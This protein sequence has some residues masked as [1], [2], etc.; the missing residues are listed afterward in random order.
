MDEKQ[1]LIIN[2]SRKLFE[3]RGFNSTSIDD[4]VKSCKISKATFY[5]YFSTKE[6]LV[7]EIMLYFNK[8]FLDVNLLID[9]K[10][11]LTGREKLKEK[12]VMVWKYIYSQSICNNYVMEVVASNKGEDIQVLRKKARYDLVREYYNSLIEVYKEDAKSVIW[13]LIFC[14]DAFIHE[15][16][17]IIRMRKEEIE[18]EFIA[19]FIIEMIEVIINTKK[20]REPMIREGFFYFENIEAIEFI[21]KEKLFERR[22]L[23]IKEIIELNDINLKDKLLEAIEVINIEFNEKRYD[24]LTIEAMIAFLEKE[25]S[26]YKEVRALDYIRNQ[27]I[28]ERD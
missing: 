10:D 16:I 11:D 23:I 5:K 26:I 15:F 13:D 22:L 12:I 19:E 9:S 7:Y 14:L 1:K 4:I 21:E 25:E 17:F 28:K 2:M 18:P 8:K 24:S 6:N 20:K 27:V 3:E